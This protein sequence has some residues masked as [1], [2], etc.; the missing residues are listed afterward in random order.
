MPLLVDSIRGIQALVFLQVR[1]NQKVN[2]IDLQMELVLS[3]KPKLNSKFFY[4]K[5]DSP[6]VYLTYAE[7]KNL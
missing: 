2:Y 4:S 1:S 6:L 3:P 7:A 5:I